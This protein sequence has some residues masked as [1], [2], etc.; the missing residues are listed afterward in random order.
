MPEV[1]VSDDLYKGFGDNTGTDV[2][3][4]FGS[5]GDVVDMRPFSTDDVYISREDFDSSGTEESLQI[6]TGL[7]SQVIIAGH[8]GEYH[9][10][11]SQTG[12]QGRIEKLIFA[13]ATFTSTNG[14]AGTAPLAKATSGK[15]ATLAEAADRLAEE[16]RAQ[17]ATMPEPGT[18]SGSGAGRPEGASKPGSEPAKPLKTDTKH[19]PATKDAHKKKPATRATH[20]K[21]LATKDTHEKKQSTKSAKPRTQRR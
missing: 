5:G 8:F 3:L 21:K 10:Y 14:L 19:T 17:L 13:D 7:T 4:D 6:V 12:Q 1:P 2:V 11:T 9:Q 20:K 16:A 18:L 15:Q